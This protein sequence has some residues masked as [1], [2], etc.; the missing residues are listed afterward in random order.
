MHVTYGKDVSREGVHINHGIDPSVSKSLHATIVV[1]RRVDVVDTN[2][3]GTQLLH[4]ARVSLA[5]LS[6]DQRISRYQ[7]VRNA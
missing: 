4:Q 3:I 2:G 6:V 7:L 1:G 5:L